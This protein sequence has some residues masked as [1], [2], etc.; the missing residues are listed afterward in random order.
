MPSTPI[1]STELE[2]LRS[3]VES[4]LT[5]AY[6]LY[7]S[8]STPDGAGGII[9]T[10]TATGSG[11]CSISPLNQ[12]SKTVFAE[13]IGSRQAWIIIVP[14]GGNAE[15]TDTLTASL[16][17]SLTSNETTFQILG[18]I[19]HLTHTQLVCVSIS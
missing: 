17:A 18:I 8:T 3:E 13:K 11:Y 9:S 16:T 4:S 7:R 15:V 10:Q 2:A 6:T 19:P 12:P 5:I 1:S 14:Y